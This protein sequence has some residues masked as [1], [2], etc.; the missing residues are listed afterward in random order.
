MKISR[1][2]IAAFLLLV[3]VTACSSDDSDS[4]SSG[5]DEGTETPDSGECDASDPVRAGVILSVSGPAGSI[6]EQAKTGVDM[7]VEETN[8][9]GG[10]NGRCVEL[11]MKDDGGDPTKAAQVARELVDQ[12]E[13]DFVIGPIL[14]SPTGSALEITAPANMPQVVLSAF[15]D[16]GDASKYPYVFRTEV[17]TSRQAVD[18][19]DYAKA[20]DM[21]SLGIIA[22]NN[23]L[24]IDAAEFLE[25]EAADNDIDIVATEF[26]ETGATSL[27]TQMTALKEANP[28]G[29]VVLSTA[30]PDIAAAIKA[31]NSLEWDVPIIGFSAAGYG[32]VTADVGEEGMKDVYAGQLYWKINRDPGGEGPSDPASKEWFDRFKEYLGE[33]PLTDQVQQFAGG[34]D[35]AMVMMT[36]MNEAG[37]TDPD[38]IKDWLEENGYDGVRATYKYSADSHEGVESDDL[39]WV[40]ASSFQD[41]THEIAA[42]SQG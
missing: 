8:A 2:V 6:G 18:F 42:R 39:A 13:V 31:R 32:A 5:S 7:A 30:P 22:V 12:E 40:V 10:V 23:A 35:A 25:A 41:G 37:S 9:D 29:V 1:A 33:D 19:V 20:N 4:A 36:A 21:D 14:S 34:Y 26:H 11:V 27:T 38:A 24:G 17:A 3:G 15:A 28:D 16:A